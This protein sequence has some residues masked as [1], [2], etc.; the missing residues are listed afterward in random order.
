M[1]NILTQKCLFLV[2]YLHVNVLG[3][4]RA[5]LS[6]EDSLEKNSIQQRTAKCI[7]HDGICK[8]KEERILS[9]KWK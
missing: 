9:L 5:H 2:V 4:E 8:Q 1:V 6:K 7:W 3:V